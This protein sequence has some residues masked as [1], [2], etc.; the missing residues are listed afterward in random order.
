MCPG[1]DFH[2]A[3]MLVERPSI[4]CRGTSGYEISERYIHHCAIRHDERSGTSSEYP[5]L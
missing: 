3:V 5:V 1:T 4:Q 2:L